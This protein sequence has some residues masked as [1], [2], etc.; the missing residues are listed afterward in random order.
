MVEKLVAIAESETAGGRDGTTSNSNIEY[1]SKQLQ[2]VHAQQRKLPMRRLT[3]I[4]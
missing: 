1:E 4:A 2:S 3:N